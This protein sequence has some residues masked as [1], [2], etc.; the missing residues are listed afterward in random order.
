MLGRLDRMPLSKTPIRLQ[1]PTCSIVDLA[2]TDFVPMCI[3]FR[4]LEF[5]C[6]SIFRWCQLPACDCTSA[7]RGS[8]PSLHYSGWFVV[9]LVMP[10]LLVS[11][12]CFVNLG[13][14]IF[15][16]CFSVYFSVNNGLVPFRL[17]LVET[18]CGLFPSGRREVFLVTSPKMNRSS[19]N[20]FYMISNT[21]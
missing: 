4:V 19:T 20:P 14:T 15:C 3:F 7:L 10:V 6:V 9:D 18:L 2:C 16:L 13:V 1:I 17:P 8:L 21:M 11:L 12:C 5:F